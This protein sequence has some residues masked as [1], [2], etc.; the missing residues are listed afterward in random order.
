MQEVLQAIFWLSLAAVVV[1]VIGGVYH[2][3]TGHD[4]E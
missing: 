3:L 4:P 2:W 1:S